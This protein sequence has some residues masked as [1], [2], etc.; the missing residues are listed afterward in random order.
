[1]IYDSL[2]QQSGIA[3]TPC[4]IG[5]LYQYKADFY[6]KQDLLPEADSMIKMGLE[7]LLRCPDSTIWAA[8]MSQLGSIRFRQSAYKAALENFTSIYA[9]SSRKGENVLA[10]RSLFYIGQIYLNQDQYSE[11]LTT[12]HTGYELAKKTDDLASANNFC[13]VLTRLYGQIFSPSNDLD[14]LQKGI[15]YFQESLSYCQRINN[16]YIPAVLRLYLAEYYAPIIGLDSTIRAINQTLE[17]PSVKQNARLYSSALVVKSMRLRDLERIPTSID[18]AK[19]AVRLS[20]STPFL[21]IQTRAYDNLREA[22]E[23]SGNFVDAYTALLETQRIRDSLNQQRIAETTFDLQV[24]HETHIIDQE[25]IRLDKQNQLLHKQNTLKTYIGFLLCALLLLSSWF[26]WRNHSQRQLIKAQK[27]GL[28]R[29]NIAKDQL[30]AVLAHDLRGPFIS[31]QGLAE[32]LTYLFKKGNT[33]R[34]LQVSEHIHKTAYQLE[35]ILDNVLSWA[36]LQRKKE[37]YQGERINLEEAISSQLRDFSPMLENKNLDVETHI[38]PDINAWVAPPVLATL[39]RNLLSNAVK[40]SSPGGKIF[41]EATPLSEANQVSIWIRD[42][43]PG[44]P[45]DVQEDLFSLAPYK[46]QKGSWGEGGTGI[47]LHLCQELARAAGGDLTFDSSYREG[48]AFQVTLPADQV[49]NQT[50]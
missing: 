5:K 10:M 30:F 25:R 26:W 42:T 34:L 13:V 21:E 3:L 33:E 40:Y 9:Y 29:A 11:A 16:T 41:L 39:I 44:V 23:A 12:C 1:M 27:E 14:S 49:I 17:V 8:S 35:A 37:P 47:G 4:Q 36:I 6:Q 18:N 2:F 43:G 22:Y 20:E 24:K 38:T 48:A 46:S 45:Q 50:A 15:T 19:E 28:E 32:K 7:V 31:F